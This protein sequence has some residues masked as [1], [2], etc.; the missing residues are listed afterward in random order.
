MLSSAP[1][2]DVGSVREIPT[3]SEGHVRAASFWGALR[4]ML[5]Y[6]QLSRFLIFAPSALEP[7]FIGPM[8]IFVSN[9]IDVIPPSWFK[10]GQPP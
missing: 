9:L 4:D 2:I 1:E 5:L 10:I 3:S 6:S 7:P 8:V